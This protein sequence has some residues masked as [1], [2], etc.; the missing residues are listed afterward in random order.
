MTIGETIRRLRREQGVTQEKLAEYLGITYQ[1]VSKWENGAGLPDI[2]LI[3]PLANFFGVSPDVLFG[4]T[5]E[6][7]R[8]DVKR[9]RERSE[10]LMKNGAVDKELRLWREAAEKYPKN[11]TCLERLMFALYLA[12]AS[13]KTEEGKSRDDMLAQALL[14]GQR[15]LEDCRDNDIAGSARQ[16]MV[17]IYSDEQS[18]CFD[19]EKALAMSE[20]ASDIHVSRQFLLRFAH[21]RESEEFRKVNQELLAISI[22]TAADIMARDLDYRNPEEKIHAVKSALA[23]WDTLFYDGNYL[24]YSGTVRG[25]W[26]T[27]AGCYTEVGEYDLAADALE[28][29]YEILRYFENLEP[30]EQHYTGLFQNVLTHTP[31]DCAKTY[32]ISERELF[33]SHL[34]Q[35]AFE[36]LKENARYAQLVRE[37]TIHNA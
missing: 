37:C 3:L 11:Y 6:S 27:L 30:T 13:G 15:I 17:Y 14:L 8:E 23:L 28:K 7:E 19:R 16:I 22:H 29:A 25:L 5:A 18:A 32:T 9:Y 36:P 31:G 1:A 35:E 34:T 4:W 26:I 12:A 2:S 20:A 10:E 21:E 33:V 24:F